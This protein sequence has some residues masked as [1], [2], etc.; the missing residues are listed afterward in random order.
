MFFSTFFSRWAFS[1][2]FYSLRN[3]LF[4]SSAALFLRSVSLIRR[5]IYVPAFHFLFF[6]SFHFLYQSYLMSPTLLDVL[7]RRRT[8]Y[9]SQCLSLACSLFPCS[10]VCI[11]FLL[12]ISLFSPKNHFFQFRFCIPFL[13]IWLLPGRTVLY[14]RFPGLIES[15][16]LPLKLSWILFFLR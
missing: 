15:I 9:L 12:I 13:Q 1:T 4:R 7:Y 2:I 10:L 6:W 3:V 8:Q 14:L 11:V 5:S 16:A